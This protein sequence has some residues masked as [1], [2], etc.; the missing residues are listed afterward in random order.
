MLYVGMDVHVRNSYLIATDA[1]G[2]VVKKGRIV[3][4]SDALTGFLDDLETETMR[5]CLESTTN[6]R[7]IHQF[8]VR[9]GQAAGIDLTAEVLDARRLRIIAES[10]V[11]NDRVDAAV[12]AELARSNLK[13]PVC[14][15][16]DDAVFALREHLRSRQD[17]VRVRTMLKNRVHAVLH[18]RGILPPEQGLFTQAGRTFL[19]QMPLDAAG[20]EILDRLLGLIDALDRQIGEST[21]S[22]R[23]LAR[24]DRWREPATRLETMP[25]IGLITALT[26]L[27]ELGDWARF[28]SRA[29]VANY[30]GLVPVVRDSN[31]KQFRGGISHRGSHHLRAVLTE[32]AWVG[33]HRVPKYQGLYARV[34]YKKNPAVAIIAV[35]REMLEDAFTLLKKQEEFKYVPTPIPSDWPT[36]GRGDREVALSAA[37]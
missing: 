20:R 28:K 7:P 27:A 3:N 26:I 6:S 4:D 24:T 1:K 10:T 12:I 25:G 31:D 34:R 2:Q 18:R 15:M 9:Y 11:K 14:Y 30:A 36:D 19:A 32:A 8:L 17:L 35:A 5:V 21:A 16:P 37:G 23:A 22:L 29:A 13:L 33:M